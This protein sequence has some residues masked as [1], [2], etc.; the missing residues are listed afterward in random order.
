[1]IT[2]NYLNKNQGRTRTKLQFL[3]IYLYINPY[4]Y[5]NISNVLET[6]FYIS[7][8]KQKFYGIR[9]CILSFRIM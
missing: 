5:I 1:M 9:R 8:K 3:Q 2:S 4:K 6:I 7:F